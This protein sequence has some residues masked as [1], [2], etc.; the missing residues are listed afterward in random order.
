MECP[1]ESDLHAY[2]QGEVSGDR[3]GEIED[4]IEDCEHCAARLGELGSVNVGVFNQRQGLAGVL[5]I[6]GLDPQVASELLDDGYAVFEKIGNGGVGTVFRAREIGAANRDVAI[7][8][9][10]ADRLNSET[11]ASRFAQEIET[12]A[13]IN[14][15]GIVPVYKAGQFKNGQRYVVMRYFGGGSVRELINKYPHGIDYIHTARLVSDVAE[16]MHDVHHPS[17][18]RQ[19]VHLDLKPE[20][21]LL[22]DKG[23]PHVT[24]FGLAAAV[25]ELHIGDAS[26]GLTLEYA[27]PEQVRVHQ[28]R[29]TGGIDALSDIW[30]LGVVLYELLS[31]QRP[32][33]GD[34]WDETAEAIE[35]YEPTGLPSSIPSVLRR[36]VTKCVQKRPTERFD[37]ALELAEALNAFIQVEETNY[38]LPEVWNLQ[39]K[40]RHECVVRSDVLQELNDWV[41]QA[42][43]DRYC[44]LL[45]PPG[46]GKSTVLAE[47]AYQ[48]GARSDEVAGP[49][50]YHSINKVNR[51]PRRF[52]QFLLWQGQRLLDKPLDECSYSVNVSEMRNSLV[53]VLERIR[54]RFGRALLIVDGLDELATSVEDVEF[55]PQCLPEGV[56]GILSCRPNIPRVR[57]LRNLLQIDDENT[58]DLPPLS[59][60][61]FDQV[62]EKSLERST[63]LQLRAQQRVDFKKLFD[64][65]K[66]NAL[67]IRHDVRRIRN[68]C[69]EAIHSHRDLPAFDTDTFASTDAEVFA[70]IYDAI[71]E[72]K[73]QPQSEA[74]RDKAKI[75]QLLS[76]AYE[77][78]TL[79][80]IRGLLRKGKSTISLDETR[81]LV[82]S[83][84]EHLVGEDRWVPFHSGL[85]EYVRNDVLAADEVADLHGLFCAFLRDRSQAGSEYRLRYQP[86]HLIDWASNYDGDNHHEPL[87]ELRCLLTDFNFLEAKVDA[88]LV[89]ELIDDCNRAARLLSEN[90]LDSDVIRQIAET[91][92]QHGAF[93]AEHPDQLFQCQFNATTPT[94]KEIDQGS[95]PSK[96]ALTALLE[97]WRN[98]GAPNHPWPRMIIRAEQTPVRTFRFHSSPI[99]AIAVLQPKAGGRELVASFA[100]DGSVSLWEPSGRRIDRHLSPFNPHVAFEEPRSFTT[101]SRHFCTCAEWAQSA[102]VLATG[103]SKGNVYSWRVAARTLE[104]DSADGPIHSFSSV[105][106]AA[107]VS[108]G[109]SPTE[110]PL[111][112]RDVAMSEN[113]VLCAATAGQGNQ[114]YV[115]RMSDRWNITFRLPDEVDCV[116]C[117][118]FWPARDDL[119][120]VGCASGVLRWLWLTPDLLE[121]KHCEWGMGIDLRT[122][123]VCMAFSKN[124][125]R[126]IAITQTW[127][128]LAC[129]ILSDASIG[130]R[131]VFQGKRDD[132]PTQIAANHTGEQLTV[133]TDGGAVVMLSV[134]VQQRKVSSH[135]IGE[136]DAKCVGASYEN[137]NCFYIGTRSGEILLVASDEPTVI[138]SPAT[139][140][141]LSQNGDA[142]A[143]S[144]ADGRVEF[145][146]T[147]TGNLI[148]CETME[149]TRIIE[150]CFYNGDRNTAIVTEADE[151]IFSTFPDCAVNQR[152]RLSGQ[153]SGIGG[154]AKAPLL[155]VV[156]SEGQLNIWRTSERV[157]LLASLQLDWNPSCLDWNVD[158]TIVAVGGEDARLY[159]I[160]CGAL[161][162]HGISLLEW[163]SIHRPDLLQN[164]K[165]DEGWHS[166]DGSDIRPVE[167]FTT[168]K[169]G[170]ASI[171][172]AEDGSALALGF[173]SNVAV[174]IST[175]GLMGQTAEIEH[176]EPREELYQVGTRWIDG[177]RLS[178]NAGELAIRQSNGMA[179]VVKRNTNDWRLAGNCAH[180]GGWV[181]D[182]ESGLFSSR[183]VY[184]Q[185]HNLDRCDWRQAM[186]YLPEPMELVG[187]NST[188]DRIVVRSRGNQK[189]SILCIEPK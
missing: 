163:L 123:I 35:R 92:T 101:R 99:T 31:G 98:E 150:G 84:S 68:A 74:G 36:I 179:W 151:V 60:A 39:Q 160:N 14:R 18:G 17:S 13:N 57:D 129:E 174:V 114:V 187:S 173:R 136:L 119:L 169:L 33:Q 138:P 183:N 109:H 85:T 70:E 159:S 181:F 4:H 127:T 103:N 71:A 172:L 144:T 186:A 67:V 73:Q 122:S 134:D 124:R 105:G 148:R 49:C 27:S 64:R 96:S 56:R 102:K 9:L 79:Q 80:E 100:W 51:D 153:F 45:G 115:A 78:L 132:R 48:Q 107:D 19:I 16:A 97:R 156:E 120:L 165:L 83:M 26:V 185:I 126:M 75:L 29:T 59:Q 180:L 62:L 184:S 21:I 111:R 25:C 34:S 76:V 22:D 116:N 139:W 28:C 176:Y 43:D 2:L 47:F 188:R 61:E 140:T 112:V 154:A 81:D 58:I 91:L 145:R 65:T 118:M 106:E 189:P 37:S 15:D 32:F 44:L 77:G 6:D 10:N 90:G 142:F 125:Q 130:I 133:I 137:E 152:F 113:A 121:Q 149:T 164:S 46:Q 110:Q 20:N 117:L 72:K 177:I 3:R 54:E 161:K 12:L 66:G 135:S 95:Q 146:E 42:V 143:V 157:E 11:V 7:K 108:E 171:A 158:G 175:V 38:N 167:P 41:D 87:N 40:Y 52:L 55:L 178:R 88:G 1:T 50:L 89:F 170:I 24:D 30:S 5:E 128:V 53:T 131:F 69:K 141:A 168:T 155:G 162:P 8:V 93:L 82:H 166:E 23:N 147:S 94:W 86:S 104:Q 182:L 63:V